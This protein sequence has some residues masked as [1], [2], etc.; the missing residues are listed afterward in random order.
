MNRRQLLQ[1]GFAASGAR[2]LAGRASAQDAGATIYLNSA[3]GVDTKPGSRDKPLKTLA[4][5][6]QRVNAGTGVGAIT[7]VLS[8]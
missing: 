4:A 5:A 2:L 7:V 3:I 8:D 6:A 1:T